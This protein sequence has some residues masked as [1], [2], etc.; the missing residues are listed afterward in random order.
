MVFDREGIAPRRDGATAVRPQIPAQHRPLGGAYSG[1]S[2]DHAVVKR[3]LRW[4][5][6]SAE[7]HEVFSG[8]SFGQ[9]LEEE[10]V[11]RAVRISPP[12]RGHA[13]HVYLDNHEIACIDGNQGR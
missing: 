13:L 3:K 9:F 10:A 2:V 11:A 7:G 6:L 4:V 12:P 1:P 5:V 8:L